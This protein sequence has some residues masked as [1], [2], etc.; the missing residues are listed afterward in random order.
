MKK[1]NV[2]FSIWL[3]VVF[4]TGHVNAGEYGFETTSEGMTE[5]LLGIETPKDRKE[6]P[7]KEDAW[8]S[9]TPQK[10]PSEPSK[11]IRVL[12]KD[13]D[14]DVWETIEVKEKTRRASVNMQIRFDVNSHTI[15]PES[16]PLLDELAETMEDPRLENRG[17]R[18][19]GHTDSDGSEAYNLHLSIKRAQAAK[20]YLVNHHR[21]SPDRLQVLG[22]GE[23]LPL[24]PNTSR[25]NK[26]LN[27]RVE[28]VL[29]D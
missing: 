2:I 10:P 3:A 4:W 29:A 9:L 22:Y 27:R 19:I 15:R 13:G 20:D 25:A 26:Q 23:T 12:K 6:G 11:T 24:T 8:E 7:K 16:L 17:F 18:I 14:Q 28:I 5:R 21:I 1:I